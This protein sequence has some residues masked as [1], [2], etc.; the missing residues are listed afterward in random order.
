MSSLEN[1]LLPVRT[2]TGTN[3]NNHIAYPNQTRSSHRSL[4]NIRP[5]RYLRPLHHPKLLIPL[6]RTTSPIPEP[7]AL[8]HYDHGWYT[9]LIL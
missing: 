9:P 8:S 2:T 1:S 5:I 7:H 3:E 6:S 4:D